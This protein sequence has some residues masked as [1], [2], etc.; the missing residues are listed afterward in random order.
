MSILGVDYGRKY[1]G[2][3]LVSGWDGQ[4]KPVAVPLP[5]LT[6]ESSGQVLDGLA[7][8]CQDYGAKDVVFGLP[9][10]SDGNEGLLSKEIRQFSLEL[11]KKTEK[12]KDLRLRIYFV[13]ES[14]TSFEAQALTRGLKKTREE[15]RKLENSLAACLILENFLEFNPKFA[16]AQGQDC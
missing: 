6:F 5:A 16:K 13:D 9:M 11:S 10:L 2:L 8:T 7:K 14:L 15:R 3:A 4:G 1:L 12:E